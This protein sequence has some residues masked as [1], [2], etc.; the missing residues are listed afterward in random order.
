MARKLT[1]AKKAFD[2]PDIIT[3]PLDID[4]DWNDYDSRRL[5]YDIFW[6]FYENTVYDEVQSSFRNWAK[7]YKTRYGLYK[8]IRN[9]Y[10][11]S[12][13]LGEFWRSHI[14][15]G[16]SK[17]ILDHLE[18][19][20]SANEDQLREAI[21]QI[22]QWSNWEIKKDIVPL[23]GSIMG[24]VGMLIV[25]DQEKQKVFFD[26]IHPG[27]ISFIE[28]DSTGNIKG[29][30]I[31]EERLDPRTHLERTVT[32]TEIALRDGD[33][34]VFTTLLN[35]KPYSWNG[36]EA[37][38]VRPYGFVPMVIIQH[39][40]VGLEWGWSEVLPG[41][42]KFREVDD[43][44]S[45]LDDQIRKLV[46][47]PWLMAGITEPVNSPT[48]SETSLTG[49]AAQNR[50]QPGR[51]EVPIF[52]GPEGASATPLVADLEIEEVSNHIG[53][54]IKEIER[55][56]P[57]LRLMSLLNEDAGNISGRAL[58]IAR[59]PSES[60][61]RQRRPNYYNAMIRAN[62]MA[63]AIAGFNGYNQFDL[64]SFDAGL[65][66]HSIGDLP[67]FTAGEFDTLELLSAKI[68]A[69]K[70][71]TDAGASLE[72]AALLVGFT[73]EEALQLAQVDLSVLDR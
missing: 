57:E 52:Y 61:V 38:W 66:D 19:G 40:D 9:V 6:A 12:Y 58:E 73:E 7:Q 15:A 35:G 34:V 27:N 43:V 42:S 48:A 68:T 50:P 26:I 60:K 17:L 63:V 4:A 32:Y 47:S 55:D 13:R 64:N 65:L 1:A 62:Q 72:Q 39:N 54:I 21:S 44:T 2:K 59:Q 67:V 29:Y 46:D 70:T 11:P 14:W 45:K 18:Y 5:R 41:Q 8:Y 37:S 20:E 33:N 28:K 25:D 71:L 53:T 36:I 24:D 23:Y 30:E 51:E 16:S 56:Y 31:Q 69:L 3:D 22:W 49:T 10:N